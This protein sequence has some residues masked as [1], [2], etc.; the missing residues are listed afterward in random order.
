MYIKRVALVLRIHTN[1]LAR[2]EMKKITIFNGSCGEC[3]RPTFFLLIASISEHAI[4]DVLISQAYCP[5][6]LRFQI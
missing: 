1:A 4:R 5:L 6:N 3:T 2:V